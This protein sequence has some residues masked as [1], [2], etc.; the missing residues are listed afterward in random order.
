DDG[1]LN[2]DDGCDSRC[3]YEIPST[4][5]D[6]FNEKEP[7]GD[8]QSANVLRIP[9]AIGTFSVKG[10]IGGPCDTDV[11]SVRVP[12]GATLHAF[13]RTEPSGPCTP[14]TPAV[15][16]SVVD[17]QGVVLTTGGPSDESGACPSLRW[18]PVEGGE[19]YLQFATSDST[20]PFKYQLEVE[21]S[22]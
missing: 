6:A 14:A 4:G 19:Y 8:F 15:M 22:N 13:M 21:V 10:Q 7:N 17:G 16:M 12:P 2:D 1:N 9:T 5:A 18:A 20:A 11:L 3:R